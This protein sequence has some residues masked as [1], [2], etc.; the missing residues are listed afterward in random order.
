[1]PQNMSHKAPPVSEATITKGPGNVLSA[2]TAVGGFDDEIK[3]ALMADFESNFTLDPRSPLEDTVSATDRC[4]SEMIDVEPPIVDQ[5]SP[6]I[7]ASKIK[8]LRALQQNPDLKKYLVATSQKDFEAVFPALKDSSG[9][10]H[11]ASKRIAIALCNKFP[12][13]KK[14]PLLPTRRAMLNLYKVM[15]AIT[16]TSRNNET[17]SFPHALNDY[18]DIVYLI[19]AWKGTSDK[20]L[21][22]ILRM[23]DKFHETHEPYCDK[24]QPDQL[25]WLVGEGYPEGGRRLV[26]AWKLGDDV[27]PRREAGTLSPREYCDMF[28]ESVQPILAGQG[29]ERNLAGCEET[30]SKVRG[31]LKDT[32]CEEE[33]CANIDKMGA[34][35]QVQEKPVRGSKSKPTSM[36]KHHVELAKKYLKH[37]KQHP[38]ICPNCLHTHQLSECT[39]FSSDA[40]DNLAAWT[41]KDYEVQTKRTRHRFLGDFSKSIDP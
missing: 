11:R 36:E 18:L 25:L 28:M 9:D 38:E 27:A 4:I 15:L 26:R 34:L 8:I 16:T 6:E 40:R 7:G 19:S 1:M 22:L 23:M 13:L 39:Q 31:L 17:P 24:L 37:L 35:V 33:F 41:V 21:K 2:Q 29:F 5:Y 20:G 14:G 12:F 30:R 32:N 10:F 3:A